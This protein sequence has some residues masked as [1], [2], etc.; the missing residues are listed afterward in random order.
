M[1]TNYQKHKWDLT[2]VALPSLIANDLVIVYPL[3]SR[4]G[5]IQYLQFTAGSN[6]GGVKPGDVFNDVFRLGEMNESRI[7]YTSSAV[8]EP[9]E[10]AGEVVLA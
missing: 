1:E 9:V 5:Y 10:A 4:T 2:T 6:K 8:V 7:N 3:K